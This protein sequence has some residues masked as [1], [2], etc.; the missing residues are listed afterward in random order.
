MRDGHELGRCAEEHGR[1]GDGQDLYVKKK[2][3]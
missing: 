2:E 3:Q 1:I